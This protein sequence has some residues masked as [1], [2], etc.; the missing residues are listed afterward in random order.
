SGLALRSIELELPSPVRYHFR[1]DMPDKQFFRSLGVFVADGFLTAAECAELRRMI[2]EA[3]SRPS[4][5]GMAEPAVYE[6]VRRTLS[7]TPAEAVRMAHRQRMLD[8]LPK[9]EEHFDVS[10]TD[11]RSD[12]LRYGEGDRFIPHSDVDPAELEPGAR[13]RKVSVVV[14]LNSAS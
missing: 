11:V 5:V 12:F 8:L 4:Q 6:D 13:R 14:F 7:A 2:R 1:A 3:P 10:L 9:L